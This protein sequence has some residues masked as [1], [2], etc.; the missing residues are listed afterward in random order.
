MRAIASRPVHC[1]TRWWMYQI[2]RSGQRR[3]WQKALTSRASLP[4][5]P[6]AP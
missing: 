3:Q 5:S 4:V 1:P 2:C 6:R